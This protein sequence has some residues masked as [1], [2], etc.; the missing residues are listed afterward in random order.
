VCWLPRDLLD[1]HRVEPGHLQAGFRHPGHGKAVAELVGTANAHL[2]Q[3]LEFTVLIPPR[4]IGIRRF[5]A[6]TIGLAL[7]TLRNVQAHPERPI[8]DSRRSRLDHAPDASVATLRYWL[9]GAVQN[10]VPQAARN[11]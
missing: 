4:Y 11:N 1:E 7:L 6:W 2:V 10:C 9:A 8:K 3:A 5:L